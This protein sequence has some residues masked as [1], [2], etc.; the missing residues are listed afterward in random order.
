MPLTYRG[1][2]LPGAEPWLVGTMEHSVLGR[3]WVYD[4]CGDPVHVA[5]LVA[6][7]LAGGIQAK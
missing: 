3:R 5:A 4:G 2:P 1:A 6:T 7:I